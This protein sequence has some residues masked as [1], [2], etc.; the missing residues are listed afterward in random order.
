MPL[1]GFEPGTSRSLIVN[2]TTGP[3]NIGDETLITKTK[4]LFWNNERRTIFNKNKHTD[5]F[6][7]SLYCSELAV[8]DSW[9]PVH[10]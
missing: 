8:E 9:N 6:T 4:M 2:H 1:P 7:Y 3:S 5:T 10:C